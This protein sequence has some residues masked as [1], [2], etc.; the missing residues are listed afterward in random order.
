MSANQKPQ[1]QTQ[2]LSP[3]RSSAWFGIPKFITQESPALALGKN[4]AAIDRP[5]CRECNRERRETHEKISTPAVEP[6]RES[7]E[8][9]EGNEDA[10][11]PLRSLSSLLFKTQWAL[12]PNIYVGFKRDALLPIMLETQFSFPFCKQRFNQEAKPK[13]ILTKTSK[14]T[15]SALFPNPVPHCPLSNP[16]ATSETPSQM[17]RGPASSR[18]PG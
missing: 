11:R 17:R 8:D 3:V 12:P 18:N 2:R 14:L 15:K 7:T 5:L 13:P 9:N 10:G 6:G 1:G 16:S 4:T